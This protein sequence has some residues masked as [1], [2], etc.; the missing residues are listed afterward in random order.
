MVLLPAHNDRILRAIPLRLNPAACPV[1]M[2]PCVI[3]GTHKYL[4]GVLVFK[5]RLHKEQFRPAAIDAFPN[6]S[7]RIFGPLKKSLGT[8]T[9][10]IRRSLD[11]VDIS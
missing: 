5:S 1:F 10:T 4:Y 11:Q 6:V 7:K 2:L 9:S 3:R 8:E